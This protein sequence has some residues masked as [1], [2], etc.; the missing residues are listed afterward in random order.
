MIP[1]PL[2]VLRIGF[3]RL[4]QALDTLDIPI[5]LEQNMDSII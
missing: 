1:F 4:G 5:Q 2:I 3:A